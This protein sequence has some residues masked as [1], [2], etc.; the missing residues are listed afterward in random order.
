MPND[1]IVGQ[2][3]H[4]SLV[5]ISHR[6]VND[7]HVLHESGMRG[8]SVVHVSELLPVTLT[9]WKVLIELEKDLEDV[10]L[11]MQLQNPPFGV[12]NHHNAQEEVCR[13]IIHNPK[14]FLQNGLQPQD[15]WQRRG[16]DVGVINM[17]RN[18]DD[19]SPTAMNEDR[20][21]RVE[22]P[23]RVREER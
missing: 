16:H 5:L 8:G 11:L 22:T 2:L 21:I 9:L 19:V 20:N 6:R 7:R 17:R 12:K 23:N 4:E 15:T 18:D 10:L 14:A 3:S 1:R 13:A